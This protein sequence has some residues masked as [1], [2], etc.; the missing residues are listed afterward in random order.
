LGYPM[1]GRKR[2]K[3]LCDIRRYLAGLINRV[4]A[5]ELDPN[6]MSKLT[7]T[8]NVLAGIVRDSDLEQRIKQ[9]EEQVKNK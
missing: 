3:T 1:A 8:S 7:Y 6:V 4:E 9:L 5:G 2:L